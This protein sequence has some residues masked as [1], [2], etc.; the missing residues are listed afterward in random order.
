MKSREIEVLKN[1]FYESEMALLTASTPECRKKM[2][3]SA[4]S[5]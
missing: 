2:L 5:R 3:D 4:Q 1:T